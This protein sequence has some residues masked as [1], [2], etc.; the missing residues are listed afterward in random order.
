M[1]R[2]SPRASGISRPVCRALLLAG[3]LLAAQ[4]AQ[5][6][7]L[8]IK[9]ARIV[10]SA[11]IA[12]RATDILIAG[13][14]I[15]RIGDDI[16]G[17]EARVIDAAGRPVS[18]G[19]F[20]ADSQI[21]VLEV[22]SVDAT[23]DG[24]TDNPDIQASL[25][26]VEAFNPASVLVPYNRSL[27][28]THTLIQPDARAGLF[29]GIASVV[30]LSG[31][32][33]VSLREAAMVVALGDAGAERAGGSRAAALAMLRAAIEDTRDYA[34]NRSA[35]NAG[36]RRDYALSRHD[37]AALIPVIEGRL[38][39]LVR[40]ERAA[41]IEQ[42]LDFA[43]RQRLNLILSGVSE[44]W[45]VA[46]QISAAGAPVILDPIRNLPSSYETLGARLDNAKLLHEAGVTLMFTGM[47][48]QNTHN[49]HLVRQSAGNAVANG[50]P[51]GAA[52]D[53]LTRNPATVFKLSGY[54]AIKT[55]HNA[56]LVIWSG[57]PLEVMSNPRHVLID[58]REFALTSRATRLRDR[59][60]QRLNR[61]Q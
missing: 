45:R 46:E 3:L 15:I 43:R 48:W 19:L 32:R 36:E 27:G 47:G 54:G 30:R 23:A 29:A 38:P 5:T 16:D 7:D 35:F 18:A 58:G 22:G 50:L 37:L 59:Y 8:L 9:N 51:Y 57:D 12:E 55:G 26:I 53:A 25:R 34:D 4:A 31:E 52:I 40:V 42:V 28:L 10:G 61:G 20:N 6:E 21:G 49:G 39:L 13:E 60:W 56:T 44:G 33:A 41:D 17:G 2:S 24:A 14:R 11:G 1:R